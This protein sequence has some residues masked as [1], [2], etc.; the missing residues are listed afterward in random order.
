METHIENKP[1]DTEGKGEG[2]T[3]GGSSME[4]YI[5]ICKTDSK[6]EFAV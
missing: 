1:V 2:G 5:T 3:N 6:W 4:T